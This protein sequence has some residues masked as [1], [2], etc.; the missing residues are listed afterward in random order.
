MFHSCKR[1]CVLVK[2]ETN[3]HNTFINK[4]K[5]MSLTQATKEIVWLREL[6]GDLGYQQL[7][8]TP[9]YCN[10]QSAITL[11]QDPKYHSRTKHIEMQHHYIWEI[12]AK[13]EVNVIYCAT[14]NMV[15]DMMTKSLPK[16]KH[17]KLTTNLRINLDDST[18]TKKE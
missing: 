4:S 9:L 18:E 12:V 7:V 13:G 8:A 15:V 3:F 11:S 5:N 14:K 6:L 1:S 10:N 2:Q 17:V 16:L